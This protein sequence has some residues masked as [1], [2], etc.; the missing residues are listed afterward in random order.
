MTEYVWVMSRLYGWGNSPTEKGGNEVS[1]DEHVAAMQRA[2]DWLTDH[3]G[4]D[5][6]IYVRSPHQGEAEGIYE[7][8][9]NGNLQI[10]N[11]SIPVP[12]EI[13]KLT[14]KAWEHALETWDVRAHAL[15]NAERAYA[16]TVPSAKAKTGK[17]GAK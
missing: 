15:T 2:E 1:E 6:E 16:A 14:N 3:E 8:K 4:D 10:L 5:V 13:M 9:A 7:K 11:Y 17:K 12:D